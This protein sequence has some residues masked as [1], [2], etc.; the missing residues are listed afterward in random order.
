MIFLSDQVL[1]NRTVYF[2]S[3]GVEGWRMYTGS[4]PDLEVEGVGGGGGA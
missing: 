4:N 3:L 1:R 2:V